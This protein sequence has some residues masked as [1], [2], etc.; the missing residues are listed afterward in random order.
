MVIKCSLLQSQ[1]HPQAYWCGFGACPDLFDGLLLTRRTPDTVL[2]PFTL[3][4]GI[5]VLHSSKSLN[6]HLRL[7][8]TSSARAA[9]C[10]RARPGFTVWRRHIA[11]LGVQYRPAHAKY[12]ADA[13]HCSLE[14]PCVT[15][16]TGCSNLR[17]AVLCQPAIEFMTARQYSL[18]DAGRMLSLHPTQAC[19]SRLSAYS[20]TVVPHRTVC[21]KSVTDAAGTGCG[22]FPPAG[23]CCTKAAY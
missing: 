8:L 14:T 17:A 22:V 13:Y 21:Y 1:L 20:D 10:V 12:V 7:G 5:G 3:R 9:Q 2:L 18:Q 16:C 6:R 4:G 11:R 19:V 23:H 15:L